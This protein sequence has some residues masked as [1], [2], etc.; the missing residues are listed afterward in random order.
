MAIA[1]QHE[2]LTHPIDRIKR[3]EEFL[4]RCTFVG[5]EVNVVDNEQI[6]RPKPIAECIEAAELHRLNELVRELLTGNVAPLQ[7]WMSFTHTVADS[8]QKMRLAEAAPA[9]DQ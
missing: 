9:V 5:K 2:R 6:N 1:R 3:V 4:L 7:R 8:L